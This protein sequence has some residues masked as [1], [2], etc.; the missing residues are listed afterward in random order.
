[1]P[2]Y[3][4]GITAARL[5]RIHEEGVVG[6]GCRVTGAR[7]RVLAFLRFSDVSRS[8][9]ITPLA[10]IQQMP[11][12]DL[13]SQ[14]TPKP[15][16]FSAIGVFLLFGAGMASLAAITLL[17]RGSPLDHVWVLNPTAYKQ[18]APL[19][20][21]AGVLFLLLSAALVMAAIGWF[22][23]RLWGWILAVAILAIQVLGDIVNCFRGE[24]LHGVTGV[25]IAV[26]LMLFLLRTK[27]RSAFA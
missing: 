15:P 5:Y 2:I 7:S 10:Y 17:W 14:A 13:V 20:Y 8:F 18:I 3:K 4:W 11:D 26:A 25:I 24:W 19:G 16:G 9:L 22:R 23:R 27:V 1:L 21:I 6:F 12:H